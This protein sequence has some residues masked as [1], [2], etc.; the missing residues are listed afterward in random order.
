MKEEDILRVCSQ[1]EE[2][3][4]DMVVVIAEDIATEDLI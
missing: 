4:A 3:G 1:A 2:A